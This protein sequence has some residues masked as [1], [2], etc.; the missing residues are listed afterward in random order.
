M[1]VLILLVFLAFARE[2]AKGLEIRGRVIIGSSGCPVA[3]LTVEI[4]P[5]RRSN[6]IKVVT[7]TNSDGAFTVRVLDGQYWL[8]IFQNGV[9]V[10]QN[11]LGGGGIVPANIALSTVQVDLSKT[12]L[13]VTAV[14][15]HGL[16]TSFSL[17]SSDTRDWR[18]TDLS[19]SSAFGLLVLDDSG[20]VTHIVSNNGNIVSEALFTLPPGSHPVAL[21]SGG[22]KVF[23]SSNGALG[24]TIYDYDRNTKRT[25][26]HLLRAGDLCSGVA[27]DGLSLEVAF[28]N[29][30][31]RYFANSN[32]GKPHSIKM[33]DL[34]GTSSIVLLPPN[35]Q[36]FIGDSSGKVYQTS[37][38]DDN[39]K[40]VIDHA[41]PVNSLAL[42]TKYLIIASGD[43]LLCYTRQDFKVRDPSTCWDASLSGGLVGV[44]VD[45]EDRAW[46][47]SRKG[48]SIIGPIT[49]K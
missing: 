32:F 16:P 23:V 17:R 29:S 5:E 11:T 42:S 27:T 12:C 49:L 26:P 14:D 40:Q 15:I 22:D 48:D 24:C 41:G 25:S 20:R 47:L 19:F 13:P 9:T 45:L 21:A 3:G 36:L 33:A 37:L 10:Y 1:R 38:G 28:G 18:P 34:T 35:Q 31:I 43:R 2:Y 46:V 4:D 7:T 30:E 8:Q 44:R 39:H 6:Q